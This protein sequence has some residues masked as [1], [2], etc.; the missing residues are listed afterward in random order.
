MVDGNLAARCDAWLSAWTGNRPDRLLAWYAEDCAYADPLCPSGL[1]GKSAV[2]AHLAALMARH[3]NWVFLRRLLWR[4][5]Q[6][7]G[8][9]W[10][11]CLPSQIG[12]D[13]DG[14]SHL[15]W[16]HGLIL[17]QTSVFDLRGLGLETAPGVVDAARQSDS[18]RHRSAWLLSAGGDG[19]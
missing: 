8:V 2:Q 14:S 13:R 15:L 17:Q 16:R 11:L 6:V 3:P 5:Q 12:L 4:D 10:R 1:F 7:T 18:Q 19:S 9:F